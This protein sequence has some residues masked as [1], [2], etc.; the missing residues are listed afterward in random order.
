MNRPALLAHATAVAIDGRGVLLTGGSGSGKS[1]LALRLIERGAILIC[2]DCCDIVDGPDGPDI[3]VRP[4]I[5]GQIEMRGVGILERHHVASA[6]LA[7]MLQLDRPPERMPDEDGRI[8]LGGWSVPGF[9][10]APFEVSAPLKVEAL[11]RR[12]VDAGRYPM[13]LE[14]SGYNRGVA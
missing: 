2:D 8:A 13:R 7:M 9:A 12:T 14:T 3:H 10:L 6:P 4:S 11:L 1:D 5:A